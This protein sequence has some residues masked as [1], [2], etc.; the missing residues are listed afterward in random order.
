ML[1]HGYG[2]DYSRYLNTFSY[3]DRI[4]VAEFGVLMGTGLAI[5]CDLFPNARVLGF[6]IDTNHFESNRQYF[7]DQ[8]A[9]SSNSPEVHKYDQFVENTEYLG[10]ILK[11][12]T[13]DVCIDDGCHFDEAILCT[14]RSVIPHLSDRFVYF[15]EDNSEIRTEINSSYPVLNVFSRGRMTVVDR[16]LN[17]II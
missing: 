16:G 10:E 17:A 11:G 4:V 2:R 7:L 14:M 9:F 6:D 5:W 12:D 1:F 8:G 13:I 3:D 15:I